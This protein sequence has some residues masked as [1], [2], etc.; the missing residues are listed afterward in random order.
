MCA[1]P[2]SKTSQMLETMKAR[3]VEAAVPLTGY[4]LANDVDTNRAYMLVHQC[5]RIDSSALCVTVHKAQYFPS[6]DRSGS[7]Q[8][9]FDRVLCDVPCSGDGTARK[10]MNIWRNWSPGS[11]VN[12]HPLQI[13]IA[14]RGA[15]L[16]KV[17]GLMVYSTCSFNPVENEAVVSALL[18]SSRGSL[19][20][21]DARPLLPGLKTR[22]G[23]TTW[24]VMDG[25][26]NK[27]R[28]ELKGGSQASTSCANDT[29]E[30]A[31]KDLELARLDMKSFGSF[32]DVPDALRRRIRTTCFPPPPEI[33]RALRL[34]LCI[35]CLP[36]DQNTGGF[37]IA[38]IRK[39]APFPPRTSSAPVAE[40]DGEGQED[41]EV[42]GDEQQGGQSKPV[43]KVFEPKEF[44]LPIP[45]EVW[46]PIKEFYGFA[47]DF[48]MDRLYNRN[49]GHK[50]ITYVPEAVQKDV[51][52]MPE[53]KLKVGHERSSSLEEADML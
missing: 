28:F 23:L 5:R 13:Q 50:V 10:T 37:F 17:G 43:G 8:G 39:V 48:P 31:E 27:D 26:S 6:L 42:A 33:A 3:A 44:F 21:V 40:V 24:V 4:V 52:E 34:E 41:A 22:A 49:G 15:N 25:L 20:L 1:A 14:K 38:A 19:E 30:T 16:L 46:P 35:R 53:S 18:Q 2:G 36:H 29:G 45:A 12:L 9:F 51:L 47:D 32:D 7:G 11:G